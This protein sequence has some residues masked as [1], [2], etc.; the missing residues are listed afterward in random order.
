MPALSAVERDGDGGGVGVDFVEEVDL[1]CVL[2]CQAARVT[3]CAQA[4]VVG[5]V[6]ADHR[7]PPHSSD[8]FDPFLT[9][10]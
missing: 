1:S 9:H 4:N 10:S 7:F 6:E 2:Q 5:E 3:C 8:P